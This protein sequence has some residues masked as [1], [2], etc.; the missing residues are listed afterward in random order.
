M[1]SAGDAACSIGGDVLFLT[2]ADAEKTGV[3]ELAVLRYTKP[4]PKADLAQICAPFS[5]IKNPRTGKAIDEKDIDPSQKAR[6]R[7]QWLEETMTSPEW[8]GWL[9]HFPSDKPA[10]VAK[11]RER[12]KAAGLT[13]DAEWLKE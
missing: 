2:N 4:D 3:A 6:I 5:S 12:V 10:A 13:C 9:A 8:R 1:K 11:L 7:A